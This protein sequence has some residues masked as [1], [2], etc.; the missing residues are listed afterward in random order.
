[1]S[2]H[3]IQQVYGIR[4]PQPPVITLRA[5]R[6]TVTGRL[7][8]LTKGN[9]DKIV[10]VLVSRD[11]TRCRYCK[12]D[13]R[14][15]EITIEHL[16]P[17]GRGGSNKISNLAISC[18]DCNNDKGDLTDEEY[19]GFLAGNL[20][21]RCDFCGRNLRPNRTYCK[22]HYKRTQ[23]VLYSTPIFARLHA[24]LTADQKTDIINPIL[25]HFD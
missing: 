19:K 18:A 6:L 20:Y 11:G 21:A 7:D 13:L 10:N 17:K 1:M 5:P 22:G 9:K 15:S 16:T 8:T 3:P 4:Y 24:E 12:K 2:A 14:R 23:E 25:S